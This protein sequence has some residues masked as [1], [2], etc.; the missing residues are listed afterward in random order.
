MNVESKKWK[1]V[2]FFST[3][4]ILKKET[5]ETRHVD[6]H[7]L[8]TANQLAAMHETRFDQSVEAAFEKGRL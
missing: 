2:G 8:P 4:L 1:V 6:I 5:K 7:Y 3:A